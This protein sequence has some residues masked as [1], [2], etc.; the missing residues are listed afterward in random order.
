M[1]VY[2]WIGRCR[3]ID[4]VDIG[5]MSLGLGL[6]ELGAAVGPCASLVHFGHDGVGHPLQVLLLAFV[7][8][9]LSVGV[10]REPVLHLADLVEQSVLFALVDLALGVIEGV[11]Y[12]GA[13]SL[14]TVLG[15]HFLPHLLVLLFE[16]LGFFHQSLN[17]LL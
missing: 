2:K 5:R 10:A 3:S 8:C 16:L 12:V 1:I 13:V 15:L 4:F 11:L 9:G 17:L 14:K 6:V 7:L